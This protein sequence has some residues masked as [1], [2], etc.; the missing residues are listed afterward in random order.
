MSTLWVFGRMPDPKPD[1]FP[2]A[3]P[4]NPHPPVNPQT[5]P[6]TK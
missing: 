3:R 1:P 2:P 5:P 4:T 6:G